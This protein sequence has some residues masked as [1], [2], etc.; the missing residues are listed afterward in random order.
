MSKLGVAIVG[1][2]GR[3]MFFFSYLQRSKHGFVAGVYDLIQARAAFM[4]NHF[5]ANTARVYE[6]LDQAIG[7]PRVQVVIIA[8]P[9]AEHAEPAV[10]ALRAGKHVYCEKPLATTLA[11]CDQI[12]TAAQKAKG[13]FYMGMNMRH[14]RLHKKLYEVLS[15]GQLGKLLTI[16][17]N[18]YYYGGRTYF[19]RWNRLRSRGGGLWITKTCHDFDLLNWFAGGRPTRVY[20]TCSLSHYKPISG[21]GTHCRQ[22]SIKDDCAD[23]VDVENAKDIDPQLGPLGELTEQAT[24]VPRDL[25]LY[26][27]EKDTFDNGI[28]VVDYENDVRATHT[29]NV[30]SAR[31]TRQMRLMGT[32]GSAEG[33]VALGIVTVWRRHSSEKVVHNL[34]DQTQSGHDGADDQCVDDF[35]HCC[36]TTNKPT[37]SWAEGR[38][39]VEV[40][41]AATKSSDNGTPVV[42]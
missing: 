22:C 27:S 2:S 42:L 12:I 7:D 38:L 10:A 3:S 34:N 31:D 41:I 6:S 8:T 26:T 33:D 21:A 14:G 28:A 13:V 19:R 18:E 16:E 20:S 4:A 36:Q 15:S 11:D 40:G 35:F 37:I 5:E 25:C 32:D 1:A 23:Y 9:D 30:V 17:S 39:A 29:L 24:G